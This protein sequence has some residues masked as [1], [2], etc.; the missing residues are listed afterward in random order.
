MERRAFG[1]TGIEVPVI[2]LGTWSTFDL[3]TRKQDVAD[4]V[5]AEVWAGGTRVF[6][7]SPMYGRAE[8]VLGRA[9]ADRRE[10]AFVA[11]K[12][13]TRS[14]RE[15]RE[16]LDDQLESFGGRVDLEQVHNLVS[17]KEHLGWLEGERDAGRVGLLGATHYSRREY[18]ELEMVMRTGRIQAIQ[19]PFNP[20]ERECEDRILPLAEE[21]ELGVLV[22]R[23]FGEGDLLPGP[24]LSALGPL[25]VDTWAQALL[26]WELSDP[27][28]HVLIP[29]TRDVGHAAANVAAGSP[30]WFDEEQRALV[31]QLASTL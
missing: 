9:L 15:G 12:I 21:L 13:W 4:D 28:V 26:K 25:G 16:Q 17:W 2:G 14:A 20:L 22:M 19:V 18:D 29:A 1:A 11:T 27:R 30:S 3:P 23:P 31:A 7:S 24:D 5:V 8:G 10:E 6:D